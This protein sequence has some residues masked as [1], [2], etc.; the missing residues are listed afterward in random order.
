[1]K[2]FH[3]NREN[4]GLKGLETRLKGLETRLKGLETYIKGTRDVY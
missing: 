1:M 2:S 3:G 4:G